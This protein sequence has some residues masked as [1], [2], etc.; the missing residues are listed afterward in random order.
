MFTRITDTWPVWYPSLLLH[1][2]HGTL[3][4][5]LNWPLESVPEHAPEDITNV[6]L[7]NRSKISLLSAW[8]EFGLSSL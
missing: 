1:I 7:W 4:L 5:N 8:I 6:Q 2:S 3:L